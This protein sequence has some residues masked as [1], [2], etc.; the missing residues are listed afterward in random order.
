LAKRWNVIVGK[1]ISA[2]ASI[3]GSSHVGN[4][5][6]CQDA[7]QVGTSQDGNWLV[8]VLSDGAGSAARSKEGSELAVNFFGEGMLNLCK[9]LDTRQP[10]SWINDFVIQKVLDLRQKLREVGGTDNLKDFHCTLLAAL[11]GERGGFAIHIGDGA[12]FGGKISKLENKSWIDNESYFCS[13]PEN[14][15]YANETFFLT[16]GNWIKHLRITPLTDLDWIFLGSDGA[17]AL[18]LENELTPR[19]QFL[20]PAAA[21]IFRGNDKLDRD[22]ILARILTDPRADKISSDDKTII[23]AARESKLRDLLSNSTTEESVGGP[24]RKNGLTISPKIKNDI[25]QNLKNLPLV[26][27]DQRKNNEKTVELNNKKSF[28]GSTKLKASLVFIAACLVVAAIYFP[29]NQHFNIDIQKSINNLIN[30]FSN[31]QK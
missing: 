21:Q 25:N 9:E 3:T 8:A 17:T 12:I 24:I 1:W 20:E 14:G 26:Q 2:N 19:R 27:E 4:G 7:S 23:F 6:P 5:Q 31:F 11:L 18:A 30:V 10:G 22:E 13:A 15:E 29:Q 28:Q 16:D